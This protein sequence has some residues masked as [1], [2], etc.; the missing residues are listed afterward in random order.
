MIDTLRASGLYDDTV[1]VYNSDHGEYLGYRHMIGKGN[2]MYEPLIRIPTII[3]F[4]GERAREARSSDLVNSTDLAPTLLTCAGCDVPA[5]M[6]GRILS[7]GEGQRSVI[8]AES[9]R[10]REY[11]A[12]SR[13]ALVHGLV[14]RG[15]RVV[16]LNRT[17]ARA[18]VIADE[19]GADGAGPLSDLS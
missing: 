11:M 14:E 9:S 19:L 7:D 17:P 8:F 5:E 16:V 18:G 12:R 6:E 1:I 13:R 2:R 10:G 3:K 4:P 15:A